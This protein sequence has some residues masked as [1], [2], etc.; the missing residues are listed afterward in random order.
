MG[1]E[2]ALEARAREGR[3]VSPLLNWSTLERI[4]PRY[5]NI[6]DIRIT[7]RDRQCVVDLRPFM[8]TAPYCL[9]ETASVVRAY[10]LFRTMGLRHLCVINSHNQVTG[11]I[12]RF[13]LLPESLRRKYQ[14]VATAASDTARTYY[15]RDRRP[16]A[17]TVPPEST[18]WTEG[19]EGG[20]TGGGRRE[21][22]RGG[23]Y[24]IGNKD[25]EESEEEDEDGGMMMRVL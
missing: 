1:P 20:G 16:S 15:S 21:E 6:N 24:D 23:G 13:D 19:R 3:L 7:D 22:E 17:Y 14:R 18:V 11:I 12:T 10:R 5:P 25:E 2:E 4:Y 9:N 8:N